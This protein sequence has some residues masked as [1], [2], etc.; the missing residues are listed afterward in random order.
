MR[1]L[2]LGL[3]ILVVAVIALLIAL[4]FVVP[5]E[6]YKGL[7]AEKVEAAT[8]R[9][10]TIAGHIGLKVFPRLALEVQDVT[11][12]NP[13]GF[14]EE[15]LL[16]VHAFAVDVS[17]LPLLHG[18]LEVNR[19]RLD[20]PIIYLEKNAAGKAN[21]DF[22]TAAKTPQAK[23]A[24]TTKATATAAAGAGAALLE[25]HNVAID[26]GQV[27]YVDKTSNARHV[28]TA[29]NLNVGLDG[30]EHP[31][32]ADFNL[33]YNNTPVSGQLEL[34]TPGKLL[35][36]Q[37]ATVNL[38]IT[39][40]FGNFRAGGSFAWDG[41]QLT[42]ELARLDVKTPMVSLRGNGDLTAKPLTTPPAVTTS[43]RLEEVRL[44]GAT[45]T[46]G[47][48]PAAATSNSAPKPVTAGW[49]TSPLAL[50]ALGAADLNATLTINKVVLE[51]V[52]ISPLN[53]KLSLNNRVLH[54]EVQELGAFQGKM[55]GSFNLNARSNLPSMA[56]RATMEGIDLSQVMTFAR[57][58][59]QTH[60][61]VA[62]NLSV[63]SLG[64]NVRDLV[65]NLSGSTSLAISEAGVVGVDPKELLAKSYGPLGATAATVVSEKST[66]MLAD[67]LTSLT[68]ATQIK[69]GNAQLTDMTL[70]GPVVSGHG[71]GNID[72]LN[73]TMHLK[74][75]P[76]L[77]P[78]V[79]M[80]G[81]G[82]WK[83][84][85]TLPFTMKGPWSAPQ[86][87]P[88]ILNAGGGIAKKA[89]GDVVN[90]ALKKSGNEQL[91]NLVGGILG[92]GNAPQQKTADP[93][94]QPEQ[95]QPDPAQMLMRGLFGG[96]K[97]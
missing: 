35:A 85:V 80:V 50:A 54:A 29:L 8:G 86:Y 52:T 81:Q 61:K 32:R 49:S 68:L 28:I 7:I 96:G 33:A 30:M 31:F 12:S 67:K 84:N 24:S 83:D 5:V 47:D 66:A 27:T 21:W 40:G 95:Q 9:K 37:P 20:S 62:G 13:T 2:L 87:I 63:D 73:R 74:I 75:T 38:D 59:L 94:Q 18:E 16:R 11:L 45:Q 91:Q 17:V 88:D 26:N 71:S 79:L 41:S 4:P 51:N 69:N 55:S 36:K 57:I 58:N 65:A 53:T 92:I 70:T 78:A 64:N 34:A 60:G 42:A 23:S 1:K 22:T 89:L 46:T 48:A 6:K 44:A 56:A 25:L 97:Q 39:S 77:M 43:L 15:N 3:A 76:Q 14:A 82:S 93:A 10:L 90:K 72:L 19:F